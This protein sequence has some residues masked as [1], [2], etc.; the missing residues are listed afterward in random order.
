[1]EN[2]YP[3]MKVQSAIEASREPIL[4]WKVHLVCEQPVKA[5]WI[6]PV[7]IVSLALS[8][9]IF[10]SFIYP[11]IALI[12]FLS[13]L[14]EYLF[15][16]HYRIT[17]DGASMRTL[18]GRAFIKWVDVKKY[19]LDDCGIKLS[20]LENPGRLE[21]YRGVYLRFGENKDTVIG[22]VRRMRDAAS[23]AQ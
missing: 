16:I 2:S 19:Y 3:E 8:L 13:A 20:P 7:V 10:H 11:L 18:T 12:I 14:S 23:G 6:A 9:I 1:M 17:E 21:P 22:T 15:P 5:L 4:A